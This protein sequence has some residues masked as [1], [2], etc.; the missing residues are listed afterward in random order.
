M[1]GW[2][3]RVWTRKAEAI[4]A[5]L[6]RMVWPLPTPKG[7]RWP[8]VRWPSLKAKASDARPSRGCTRK[9]IASDAQ[10]DT[11]PSQ[12]DAT[13]TMHAELRPQLSIDRFPWEA[14]QLRICSGPHGG[15]TF[16]SY[17]KHGAHADNQGTALSLMN[18]THSYWNVALILKQE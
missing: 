12:S 16:C 14:M 3:S 9:A 17:P 6:R 13:K 11:R 10:G 18:T 4:D 2:P 8:P 15:A 5:E 7:F 1:H